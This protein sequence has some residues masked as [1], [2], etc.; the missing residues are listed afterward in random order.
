MQTLET[1]A[2]NIP[3]NTVDIITAQKYYLKSESITYS[4][5]MA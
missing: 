3:P 5:I 1:S 4:D 2:F